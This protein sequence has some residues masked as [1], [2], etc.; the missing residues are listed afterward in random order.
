MRYEDIVENLDASA[1]RALDFLRLASDDRLVRVHE[2]AS[3]TI[4]GSP[5]FGARVRQRGYVRTILSPAFKVTMAFFQF[6]DW[7]ACL[8]R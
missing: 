5:T 3:S 1:R 4:A 2:Y 6:E 7:P 8:V